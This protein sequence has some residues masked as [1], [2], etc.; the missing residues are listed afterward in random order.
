MVGAALGPVVGWGL[1][2]CARSDI[3]DRLGKH[4]SRKSC[5]TSASGQGSL[6]N[7]EQEEA[8]PSRSGTEESVVAHDDPSLG[9]AVVQFAPHM[10]PSRG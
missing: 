2:G 8:A 3:P 10:V 5:G 6:H 4:G 9:S 7:V 1:I